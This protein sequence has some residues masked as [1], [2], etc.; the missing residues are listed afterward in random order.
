MERG[1]SHGGAWATWVAFAGIMMITL[2]IFD[3][4]GGFT[5]LVSDDYF[6]VTKDGLL[7]ENYKVFGFIHLVFGVLLVAVGWALLQLRTWARITALVLVIANAALHVAFLNAQPIWSLIMVA[8]DV[9]IIYA[10][11]VRWE[12]VKR[13]GM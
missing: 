8:I 12:D 3:V 10:L 11:T 13:A 5:A 1:T 2:G 7:I 6:A 9:L 4:L